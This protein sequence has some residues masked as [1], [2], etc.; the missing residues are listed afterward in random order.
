[1]TLNK[2]TVLLVDDQ[3]LFR[4][5]LGSLMSGEPDMEVVGEAGDGRAAL[6]RVRTLE[7][8]VVLM[9]INMPVMN[10]IE[11][12]RTIKAERP[13]TRLVALT[14]SDEDHDLFEAI[15]A[16]AEGYLLKNLRPEELFDMIRGVMRGETPLSPAIA[17][18]LLGEFRRRPAQERPDPVEGALTARE[19][20]ILQL[21]AD[22]LSNAEIA[23]RL[24]ITEGTVKNHL[25]NILEKLHLQ[26]RVQ[27]AAYA[28]RVG[29]VSLQRR[30][31]GGAPAPILP[32]E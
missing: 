12:I 29:L 18:K 28:L 17:G 2:I 11:A 21:V 30:E 15:K 1:M 16:G 3:V 4:R 7:P 25:H 26:N 23:T 9:D 13:S 10:G 19:L 22:G 27:A 31:D 24:F 14:V 20:E 32:L 8:D 5:G 6:E